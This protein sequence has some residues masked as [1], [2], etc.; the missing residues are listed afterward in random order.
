MEFRVGDQMQIEAE[1]DPL[2]FRVKGVPELVE[3]SPEAKLT[4]P[5]TLILH[6]PIPST[7]TAFRPRPFSSD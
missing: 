3:L 4:K 2:R 1:E 6:L 5:R 7:C